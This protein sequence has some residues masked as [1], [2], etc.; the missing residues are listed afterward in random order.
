VAFAA[1]LAPVILICVAA[2][3]HAAHAAHA[4]T[5][6]AVHAKGS[7]G[8][9]QPLATATP[10]PTSGAFSQPTVGVSTPV[11]PAT[12]PALGSSGLAIA[13]VLGCV[14]GVL[15]LL[16]GSIALTALLRGGYGPFLL[17]L[18]PGAKRRMARERAAGRERGRSPRPSGNYSGRSREPSRDRREG[19]APPRRTGAPPSRTAGPRRR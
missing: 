12:N 1:A 7:S 3:A 11:A 8:A 6:I 15:G 16:L 4:H 19:G 18:L 14:T 10:E 9:S 17:T 2:P 5:Q 13:T